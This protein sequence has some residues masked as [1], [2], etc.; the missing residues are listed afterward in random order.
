M[1]RQ[2]LIHVRRRVWFLRIAIVAFVVF[3]CY[4]SF[5]CLVRFFSYGLSLDY[6]EISTFATE[7]EICGLYVEAAKT[8]R[9]YI[10]VNAVS[11]PLAELT[12]EDLESLGFVREQR[13]YTKLPN[14]PHFS[15]VDI[16][17]NGKASS[18]NLSHVEWSRVP[19]SS[20]PTGPFLELPVK[21][22]EFEKQFGKPTKVKYLY[23][24]IMSP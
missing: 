18:L 11:K 1:K 15:S 8:A 23:S 7:G 3:T 9:V 10:L 24:K 20:S 14:C 6:N 2:H 21:R 16:G 19:F 4:W 22:S 12:P 17:P 13:H 5:I